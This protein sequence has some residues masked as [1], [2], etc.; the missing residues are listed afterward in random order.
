MNGWAK[1]PKTHK[2]AVHIYIDTEPD[3]A[4][5]GSVEEPMLLVA[6]NCIVG[7]AAMMSVMDYS[8][9]LAWKTFNYLWKNRVTKRA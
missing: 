5:I 6:W 4:E 2:C 1:L 9:K 3:S 8:G 7:T